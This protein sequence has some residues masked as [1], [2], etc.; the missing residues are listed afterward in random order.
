MC[1]DVGR[2]GLGAERE[3]RRRLD[4]PAG[5]RMASK[6][7]LKIVFKE[8]Y[9]RSF[10]G[11]ALPEISSAEP[12][13][14]GPSGRGRLTR[15]PLTERTDERAL[16]RRCL[17]GGVLGR[18]LKDLYLGGRSPRPLSELRVS[19]YARAHG[20]A[21]PEILAAAFE[22]VG[23][24]FYRGAV[25]VRE[26]GPS[27]DLQAELAALGRATD[28]ETLAKK[29]RTISLLGKLVADMHGAG[30]WHADLHLKNVLLAEEDGGPKLYLLD[31]DAAMIFGT[32]S[33]FRKRINLMRLY[34]SVEKVNRESKVITRTDLLRFLCAYAEGSS[35]SVRV[36]VERLS[37]MLPFWRLKWKLSDVL[38][39]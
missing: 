39:V 17:R 29:R 24:L 20:V 4:L 2:V 13:G 22:R 27:A 35:Q 6:D 9:A 31:L 28:A 15:M 19:Q 30:I 23:P 14:S 21:T 32:L 12:D 33:D 16:V 26:I 11:F 8:G 7:G 10:D 18:F 25:V 37:R 1:P 3:R 5:Y 38:G 34:R 36:L